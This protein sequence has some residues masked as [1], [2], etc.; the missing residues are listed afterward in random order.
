MSF[1]FVGFYHGKRA[2]DDS[3]T[4]TE[5]IMRGMDINKATESWVYY[6][7]LIIANYT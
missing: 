1:F 5:D 2:D 7:K 4:G 6:Y 3:N